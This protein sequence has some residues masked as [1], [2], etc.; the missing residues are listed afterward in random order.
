[1]SVYKDPYEEYLCHYGVIGMKCGIRR[2]NK[3]LQKE[4]NKSNK[5][6]DVLNK[7]YKKITKKI[8]KLD[9]QLANN[10]KANFKWAK[11]NRIK[12]A[13][14]KV[15]SAK[16]ARK[17]E[18]LINKILLR[19]DRLL[20]KSYKYKIK[21]ESLSAARD[22]GKA[23]VEKILNKLTSYQDGLRKIKSIDNKNKTNNHIKVS[24]YYLKDNKIRR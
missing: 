17:S 3:L 18:K 4:S 7:N 2:A 10:K 13:K 12:E 15:K 11:N 5:A 14:Y 1:M 6:Y 20:R 23:K 9:I 22:L 16:Y 19:S 21:A 24:D 8:D